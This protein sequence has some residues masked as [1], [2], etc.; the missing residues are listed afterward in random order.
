MFWGRGQLERGDWTGR[1]TALC[2]L[3]Q[4]G[5]SRLL[6]SKYFRE[7]VN[8]AQL[9]AWAALGPGW[10]S[11]SPCGPFSAHSLALEK[12]K[13]SLHAELSSHKVITTCQK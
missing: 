3:K 9:A 8:R 4:S 12:A 6:G 5:P 7:D 1:D 10:L 13:A 2:R 11:A